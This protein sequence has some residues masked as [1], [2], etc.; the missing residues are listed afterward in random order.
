MLDTITLNTGSN[1]SG[2]ALDLKG[3]CPFFSMRPLMS[4]VSTI[5]EEKSRGFEPDNDGFNIAYDWQEEDVEVAGEF[6]GWWT[7]TPNESQHA[8]DTP[9]FP[10]IISDHGPGEGVE[11]G[12]IVSYVAAEMPTTFEALKEDINFGDRFLQAKAELIKYKILGQTIPPDQEANLHPMLL[13]YFAKR[14][15]LELIKPGIDYWS[16]QHRTITTTQTSEI[17]SYP[18][19]VKSLEKLELILRADCKELWQEVQFAVPGLPQRKVINFPTSDLAGVLGAEQPVTISAAFTRPLQD[20]WW[21][22]FEL[23]VF[24]FP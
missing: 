15:A 17:A 6:M 14:L 21:G 9:E 5:E 16:R 23:G 4:R 19:I 12:A 11:T 24:P 3:T 2:K 13:D 22:D 1:A 10:I 20:H 18:E 8:E 7:F